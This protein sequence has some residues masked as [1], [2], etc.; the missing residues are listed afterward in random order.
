MVN[1]I[2]FVRPASSIVDNLWFWGGVQVSFPCLVKQFL[3]VSW[4]GCQGLYV[5][6]KDRNCFP[7]HEGDGVVDVVMADMEFE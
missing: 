2:P 6:S 4:D 3:S 5:A 7:W 1:F